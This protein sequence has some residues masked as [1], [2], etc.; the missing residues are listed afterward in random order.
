MKKMYRAPE[1]PQ[2]ITKKHIDAL[3][4]IFTKG[5]SK[6][7]KERLKKMHEMADRVYNR[8]KNEK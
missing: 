3:E 6:K 7:E 5:L 8:M 2:V 4:R 1:S